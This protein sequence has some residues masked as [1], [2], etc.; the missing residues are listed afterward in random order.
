MSSPKSK[1]KTPSPK[2]T[3]RD[4]P[5]DVT[6]GILSRLSPRT[7]TAMG[8]VNRQA[9]KAVAEINEN[10]PC[11]IEELSFIVKNTMLANSSHM[12]DIFLKMQ[13]NDGK[14][15]T[16]RQTSNRNKW[17]RAPLI[18]KRSPSYN[19][20]MPKLVV[21]SGKGS[22]MLSQHVEFPMGISLQDY[23]RILTNQARSMSVRASIKRTVAKKAGGRPGYRH[24]LTRYQE[25]YKQA[26]SY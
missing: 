15:Y 3:F 17:K 5:R 1:S 22:Y 19:Q 11:T 4:I 18:D 13:C 6:R 10:K 7:K 26:L 12:I 14:E 9:S 21:V 16:I 8:M 25:L 20:N 23:T 2:T 24:Y